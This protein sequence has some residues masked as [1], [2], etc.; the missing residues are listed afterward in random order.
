MRW[1]PVEDGQPTRDGTVFDAW[2][3]ALNQLGYSVDWTVLNAADYGDPTS[4]ERFFLAGSQVGKATFPD[5]THRDDDPDRP[6]GEGGTKSRLLSG[7][8][9]GVSLWNGWATVTVGGGVNDRAR[10]GGTMPT[11]VER[12]ENG[13]LDRGRYPGRDGRPGRMKGGTGDESRG[14]SRDHSRNCRWSERPSAS[15]TGPSTATSAS[16][17]SNTSS[18]GIPGEPPRSAATR[19]PETL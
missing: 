4:R 18:H 17:R 11:T 5:P 2:I 8:Y 6:A 3:N 10:G 1:G 9:P 16:S 7:C 19:S 13:G 14:T 15:S 12:R